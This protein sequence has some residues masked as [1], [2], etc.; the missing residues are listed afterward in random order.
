MHEKLIHCSLFTNNC[1]WYHH[2]II[3]RI[4]WYHFDWPLMLPGGA[5]P[6]IRS[7]IYPESSP[8]R[9]TSNGCS[10]SW[11]RVVTWLGRCGRMSPFQRHL[12]F[13]SQADTEE[14]PADAAMPTTSIHIPIVRYRQALSLGHGKWTTCCAVFD[15]LVGHLGC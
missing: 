3:S 11:E 7:K 15:P 12:R 8:T 9:C 6:L 10:N 4:I 5:V 14:A 13:V 1:C 2:S